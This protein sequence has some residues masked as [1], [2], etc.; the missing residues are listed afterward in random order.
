MFALIL[1]L[2]Y[3][4]VFNS[5]NSDSTNSTDK[6]NAI[7]RNAT[8]NCATDILRANNIFRA[9]EGYG[10]KG[11]TSNNKGELT[12]GLDA[13]YH[14]TRLT[15][16]AAAFA[17]KNDTTSTKGFNVCGQKILWEPNHRTEIRPYTITPNADLNRITI[18]GGVESYNRFYI[19]HIE[20]E[21][22]DPTPNT[23]KFTTP[24]TADLGTLLLYD[25]EPTSDV[26]T[27]M[28]GTRHATDS[29]RL[30]LRK[31][32]VFA[33]SPEVL[34]SIGGE[35][36]VAYSA[37][38]ERQYFDTLVISTLGK[39]QIIPLQFY[40]KNYA[41]PVL[42]T[43][44]CTLTYAYAEGLSDSL[45]KSA[46][47]EIAQCGIRYRYGAGTAKSWDGFYYTDRDT[48]TN[49][50]Y[51]MYSNNVRYFNP[52][53][54]KAS[55]S[56][57]DIEHR[58][59][60]SWWGGTVNRA[61]CDLYHLV[62][63]DLSAN[64]SKSNHAPGVPTDTTFW[65]GSFATGSNPD[66]PVAK[67]FCPADEYKGDFARTYFYV[68]AT[69]GDELRWDETKAEPAACVTNQ[70]YLE[71]RPWLIELLL[72]WHN[73]DPVSE[74]ERERARRVQEIQGNRNPFIDYPDLAEYIWGE[75]KGEAYHFTALPTAMEQTRIHPSYAVKA[76]QDGKILIIREGRNYT[77]LGVEGR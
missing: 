67:V 61:Y 70:S 66:Y 14:I 1:L 46:V 15:V 24:Y 51:D 4:I 64:R 2:T 58:L 71:F 53:E 42:D 50:V 3:S 45:L 37:Q 54:P 43:I 60:K 21:A 72:E 74:A 9:K 25:Y 77:I 55:V 41:A 20:F 68:A 34:P 10:I 73:L 75:H 13:T 52:A 36:E 7:V 32:Q 6:L 44:P 29:L 16:Y 63:G 22:E 57:F 12:I 11:G 69:Y 28:I 23:V 38:T 35:F 47:G 31:G 62:P 19:E 48:L 56:G 30:S 40:A 65:N 76:L 27:L 33:V 59:P 39:T 49:A 17:H 5:G 8:D 26:T 18:A